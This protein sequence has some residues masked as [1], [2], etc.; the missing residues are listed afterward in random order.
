MSEERLVDV[1]NKNHARLVAEGK[2]PC[3][4]KQLNPNPDRIGE[5][6]LAMP[7][8]GQSSVTG[9]NRKKEGK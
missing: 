4:P 2:I 5:V 1:L 7:S 6:I 9:R 8:P 3:K